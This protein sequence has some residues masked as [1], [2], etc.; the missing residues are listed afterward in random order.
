VGKPKKAKGARKG[1]ASHLD[2]TAGGQMLTMLS[3]WAP[4]I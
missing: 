2:P 3:F 4:N 1:A